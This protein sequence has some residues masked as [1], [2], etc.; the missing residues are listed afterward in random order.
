[1]MHGN[2]C[3]KSWSTNQSAIA[4][5]SGEAEF[6]ALVKGSSELLGM[7]S[8]AKDLHVPLKGHL[9]SDSSA[10]IGISQRRGLGKVKH[11]H[12]QYLWVQERIRNKDFALHKVATDKNRADLMTKCLSRPAIDKFI[13]MLGCQEP[14]NENKLALK[15]ARS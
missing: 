2:R 8:I 4:I 5:S 7:M 15:V 6:Y 13:E 12:T 11:M 9:H 3:I 14:T 10:A 1:M